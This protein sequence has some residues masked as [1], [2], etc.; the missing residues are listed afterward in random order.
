MPKYPPSTQI[1]FLLFTQ[2]PRSL[3]L[4][5]MMF[6]RLPPRLDSGGFLDPNYTT[7]APVLPP[8]LRDASLAKI[9]IIPRSPL[10]PPPLHD[11]DNDA[12]TAESRAGRRAALIILALPR[13]QMFLNV[14]AAA[15]SLC[16]RRQITQD[17]T[18]YGTSPPRMRGCGGERDCQTSSGERKLVLFLSLSSLPSRGRRGVPL[19]WRPLPSLFAHS[20]SHLFPRAG[21]ERKE[22]GSGRAL[23]AFPLPPLP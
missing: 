13:K 6:P 17:H 22:E 19:V 14:F 10:S 20:S 8:S 2:Q 11:N 7:H 21:G 5:L 9:A 3:L 4:V 15:T 12:Y 1:H 23:V 16:H 18:F